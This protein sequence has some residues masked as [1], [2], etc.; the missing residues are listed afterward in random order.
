MGNFIKPS[1]TKLVSTSST[2]IN[3]HIS[4]N[5]DLINPSPNPSPNTLPNT[6]P[7]T[8][9]SQN[10]QQNLNQYVVNVES[11]IYTN[12]L[13]E[14]ATLQIKK[15]TNISVVVEV[16]EDV[17]NKVEEITN[18]VETVSEPNNKILKNTTD[19]INNV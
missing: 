16:I 5:N 9:K 14:D 3:A 8:P 2:T 7:N 10:L 6:P 19:I 13:L 17:F 1:I 12:E 11:I 15:L 4:T 18:N